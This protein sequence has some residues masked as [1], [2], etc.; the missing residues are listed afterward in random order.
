MADLYLAAANGGIEYTN[1]DWLS[2]RAFSTQ[3]D[4]EWCK[5]DI[6]L[7]NEPHLKPYIGYMCD[8]VL[9]YA[10]YPQKILSAHARQ[11]LWQR[12]QCNSTQGWL[13]FQGKRYHRRLDL[14]SR[15][16]GCVI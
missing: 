9:Q 1:D 13:G 6:V 7:G 16:A 5:W 4:K 14:P 12:A 8:C 10:A 2:L 11:Q 3:L 15:M